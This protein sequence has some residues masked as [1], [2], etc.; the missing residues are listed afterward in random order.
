MIGCCRTVSSG[1]PSWASVIGRAFNR[2]LFA[3]GFV[4]A[5]PGSFV[6]IGMVRNGF[7]GGPI[8]PNPSGGYDLVSMGFVIIFYLLLAMFC[9]GIFII[10]IAVIFMRGRPR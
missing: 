10:L 1:P 6:V 3:V 4:L 7:Y 8:L 9:V 5:L 2:A